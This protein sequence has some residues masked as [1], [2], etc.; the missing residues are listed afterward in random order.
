MLIRPSP[1]PQSLLQIK[2][3]N[4]QHFKMGG[5][6]IHYLKAKGTCAFTHKY[7]RLD[8][9]LAT[10]RD[11]NLYMIHCQAWSRWF[12]SDPSGRKAET[13]QSE[14]KACSFWQENMI[15]MY[16]GRNNNQPPRRTGCT[17]AWAHDKS[18]IAN[19]GVLGGRWHLEAI[20]TH[21]TIQNHTTCKTQTLPEAWLTQTSPHSKNS[22]KCSH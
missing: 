4:V 5:H 1:W 10:N 7:K 13:L 19:D 6:A 2:G 14:G 15:R 20:L 16:P 12:V 18:C 17:P 11:E 22:E 21:H 9:P 8:Q 3:Q